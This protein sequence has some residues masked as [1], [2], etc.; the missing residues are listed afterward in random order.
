MSLSSGSPSSLLS[1]TVLS[2]T[3]LAISTLVIGYWLG[4]GRSLFAYNSSLKKRYDQLGADSDSDLDLD[5]RDSDSEEEEAGEGE[6][7]K[8]EKMNALRRGLGKL[9]GGEECKMV[10]CVRMDLKMDKG[11]MAAQCW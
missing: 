4:V 1:P 6:G 8:G 5:L 7:D 11:K 2:H 9:S 3:A 10:L